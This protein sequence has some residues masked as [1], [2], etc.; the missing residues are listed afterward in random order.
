MEDIV[1]ELQEAFDRSAQEL[2]VSQPIS[3]IF[4]FI[5]GFDFN[6]VF[7]PLRGESF[8]NWPVPSL[9]FPLLNVLEVEAR[10][11]EGSIGDEGILIGEGV[12]GI[13]HFI[14]P[15]EA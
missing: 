14:V 11:V 12:S 6:V 10:V 1:L 4:I 7:V 9:V 2:R 13:G 5:F 15:W 8:G 3:N